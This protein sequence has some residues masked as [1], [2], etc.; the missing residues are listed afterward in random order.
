MKWREQEAQGSQSATSWG[1][2]HPPKGRQA[3]QFLFQK[4]RRGKTYLRLLIRKPK[5]GDQG[6]RVSLDTLECSWRELGLNQ[7]D[8]L[9]LSWLCT[10][11]C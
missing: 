6:F 8:V 1:R 7:C 2:G 9:A 11:W 5:E 10:W 4:E 3:E